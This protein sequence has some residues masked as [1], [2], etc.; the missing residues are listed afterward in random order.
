[1]RG[2]SRLS[3]RLLFLFFNSL[4]VS[5]SEQQPFKFEAMS[6]PTYTLPPLPYTYNV[7]NTQTD[8]GCP[9]ICHTDDLTGIGTPHL[10]PDYGTTP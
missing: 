3:I 6:A 4:K 7:S 5:A 8:V 9:L 2:V 1:M 10:R